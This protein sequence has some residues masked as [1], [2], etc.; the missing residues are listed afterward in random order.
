MPKVVPDHV[1]SGPWTCPSGTWTCPKWILNMF[2]ADPKYVQSGSWTCPVRTLYM[3]IV[4][5]AWMHDASLSN[6]CLYVC[7]VGRLCWIEE[8]T[9]GSPYTTLNTNL[10]HTFKCSA[11]YLLSSSIDFGTMVHKFFYCNLWVL[12]TICLCDA[13]CLRFIIYDDCMFAKNT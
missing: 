12:C 9:A 1:Q 3:C 11:N 8:N 7:V 6:V 5:P 4:T 10:F 2:S 13:N